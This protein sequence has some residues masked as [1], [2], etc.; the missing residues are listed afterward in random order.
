MK[1]KKRYKKLARSRAIPESIGLNG[2]GRRFFSFLF[3]SPPANGGDDSAVIQFTDE[4]GT[5]ATVCDCE[6][7]GRKRN[8]AKRMREKGTGGLHGPRKR[9]EVDKE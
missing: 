5:R 7:D 4:W 1:R 8:S 3:L 2:L 9:S 6:G